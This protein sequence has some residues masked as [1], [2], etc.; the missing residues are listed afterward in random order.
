MALDL[1]VIG[2]KIGPITSQYDWKNVVLYALGVGA[3][4]DELEYCYE[5]QL[6]VIPSFAVT[7]ATEFFAQAIFGCGANLA[8][9]LHGEHDIVFHN[10]IPPEGG[11]LTTE[12]AITHIYDKGPGRG[13]LIV[14]EAHTSHANG[15]K[16]FTNI[17]TLFARLD[18]GFGG[19]DAPKE[20]FEFPDRPPDVEEAAHPSR[21]QPLLYRLSGDTFALHVDPDFARAAG[22]EMPIMHGLCTHG[23]ACRAVIKH[24]FPGEPERLTRFRNRFSKPLYP[25][26]PI[27]TQIWKTGAGRAVFKVLNAQTGEIVLD[28]GVVEWK[29]EGGKA[30]E[31]E[32]RKTEDRGQRTEGAPAERREDESV[33]AE[34]AIPNLKSEIRFDGRVAIVTGAG[35]GLGRVYALELAK[36]GAKVVVNDYGGARDGSGEGSASPADAVVAEIQNAGGIAVAN[37]DS[38]ATIE[39]GERIVKT[40]LDHF[41][42][43]DILINNAGILRDKSFSNM[44]PEMWQAVLAVHLQGAYNVT[45]PAF[46]AMKQNGYG[47]IVMTTSAAGLFGNFGQTN[48]SSAKLGLVGFM[49][50]LKLEGEKYNIKVNTVAP[51]AAT[52]LTQDVMPPEFLEKLKPEFVAPLVLYLC[53]EQCPVSGN[54]YNAGMGYYSRAAI[55]SGPGV[56][57]GQEGEIPAPEAVAAQWQRIL[58]LDGAQ[59]YANANTALMAMLSGGAKEQRSKGESSSLPIAP[60]PP[61][62]SA[63]AQAG[64]RVQAVFDRMPAMFQPGAAAGVEVIFQFRITGPEGGDWHVTVK[65]K[66]CTVTP[67]THSKPTTTLKMVDEDFLKLVGGQLPAM[68]AYTSGKLKIEGDVMKSQLVQKLFKF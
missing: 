54:I 29:D 18:G 45:R 68:Q 55:V 23:Y 1:S 49:N 57:V 53:A 10:P 19:P 15:Q 31:E 5:N 4:F 63:P 39:G 2:K 43:V 9:I 38:V 33:K 24:L 58:S 6:K 42:K 25:G 67:G 62:S 30:K 34:S 28:R 37:Y 52:R 47:R 17:L 61:P 59:E 26:V 8:G 20:T 60:P 27:K 13:A 7:C 22:F 14:A 11:T 21:N 65:D 66:T 56:W 32:E 50:T 64:N 51:L 12:G 46:L 40:A 44:T 16:L 3:G 35:G 41:G 48:Y 36:R